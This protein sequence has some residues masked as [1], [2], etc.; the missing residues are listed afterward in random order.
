MSKT[1]AGCNYCRIKSCPSLLFS[2]SH[3]VD[4]TSY[5]IIPFIFLF[6]TAC[7][8]HLRGDVAL[9]QGMDTLYIEAAS[10]QLQQ[11]ISN[12]LKIASAGKLVSTPA[13]AA[14]VVKIS[15]ENLNS[16]IL[17]MNAAGR[18]NQLELIYQLTFSISDAAGKSLL[19]RQELN[20]KREYFN[21][22]TQILGKA[23][24]EF[25]IRAEMYKQ[26]ADALIG[27]INTALEAN[28]LEKAH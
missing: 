13:E 24:E 16:Q 7:S 26:A 14:V 6:L 5:K 17:S 2:T 15:K 21:D 23:N 12:A 20:V 22:Q 19:D 8:Y 1:T 4:M 28:S 9:A 10:G 18:S 11:E 25:V 27:R 3:S